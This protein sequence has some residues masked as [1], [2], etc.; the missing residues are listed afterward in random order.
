MC[1]NWNPWAM[2]VGMYNDVAAMEKSIAILQN[3][4]KIVT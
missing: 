3:K 1:I 4:H 2:L